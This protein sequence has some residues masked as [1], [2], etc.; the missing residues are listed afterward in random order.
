MG[1]I[2][3]AKLPVLSAEVN[4]QPLMINAINWDDRRGMTPTS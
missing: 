1:K 2:L 3:L 4:G